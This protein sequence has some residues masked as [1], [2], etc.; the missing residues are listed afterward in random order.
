[1]E[2]VFVVDTADG[3]PDVDVGEACLGSMARNAGAYL[4]REIPGGTEVQHRDPACLVPV[5]PFYGVKQLTVFSPDG[6]PPA[7]GDERGP[8][9]AA[10]MQVE[11]AEQVDQRLV[12]ARLP[13]GLVELLV[14]FLHAG[15]VGVGHA[16]SFHRLAQE[17]QV[18]VG[19]A[20]GRDSSRGRFQDHPR[21]VD[22]EDLLGAAG[23]DGETVVG[24]VGKAVLI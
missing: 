9:A 22:V 1:M 11:P 19:A 8:R 17:H 23:T 24:A 15:P 16:R 5:T 20:L 6:I 14:G 21:V 7:R 10:E 12:A 3:L 18:V 13:D 2:P 4:N